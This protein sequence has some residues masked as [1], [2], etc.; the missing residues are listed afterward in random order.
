LSIRQLIYNIFG[1][2]VDLFFIES[3]LLTIAGI[4]PRFKKLFE[5]EN[6]SRNVRQ[7]QLALVGSSS[8]LS[9]QFI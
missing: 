2:R 5:D 8:D 1:V 9:I 7:D 3:F 6:E 4:C